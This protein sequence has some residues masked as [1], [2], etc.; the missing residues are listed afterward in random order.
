MGTRVKP[1]PRTKRNQTR[2]PLPG[3][4]FT[5]DSDWMMRHAEE[6]SLRYPDKWVAVHKRCVVAVADD[7]G[8]AERLARE[9][10][11]AVEIPVVFMGDS[12]IFF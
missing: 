8:S 4:Q 12:R 7:M 3:K 5:R 9:R 1:A 11:G 2:L 6:L 10:T